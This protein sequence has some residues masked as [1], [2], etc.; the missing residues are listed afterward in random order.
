MISEIYDNP[1]I[2]VI[3]PVYNV[4][5]YLNRCLTSL[6]EQSYPCMEII[7]VDDGSSDNSGII[8]DKWSIKYPHVHV[9]HQENKGVSAARNAGLKIAR[10]EFFGFVDPDD[11]IDKEM[12]KTLYEKMKK[13]NADIGVCTWQNEY[14]NSDCVVVRHSIEKVMNGIE[15][16]EYD[17]S[18]G[19]YITCNKLFSRKVCSNVLYDESI[20]NGEDRV[21][22]VTALL[23]AEK[24]VYINKPYYHYC[25][26]AN[27]AGTKKYTCEDWSLINACQKIRCLYLEKGG[28]VELTDSH[29]QRAYLQILGMIGDEYKEHSEEVKECIN[30]LRTMKRNAI[31][32]KYNNWKFKLRFLLA[33]SGVEIFNAYDRLKKIIQGMAKK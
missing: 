18:N 22:D 12:Y 20:I 21:F 8:C 17:L 6:I 10:G 24:V 19:M 4:A 31:F 33:C 14:E 32:N 16:V 11:Y 5:E 13:H 9:I 25:H 15:A 23:N 7:L 2:S 27:S 1:I 28:N 3:V 29:L 26:R 30:S